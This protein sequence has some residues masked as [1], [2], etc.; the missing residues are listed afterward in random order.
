MKRITFATNVSIIQIKWEVLSDWHFIYPSKIVQFAVK[1]IINI[2]QEDVFPLHQMISPTSDKE[3]DTSQGNIRRLPAT[4]KVKEP[5]RKVYPAFL[6]LSMLVSVPSAVIAIVSKKVSS[7]LI[8]ATNCAGSKSKELK[9][10]T[11]IKPIA[12]Q[13]T[14]IFWN[15][16]PFCTCLFRALATR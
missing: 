16:C 12:N 11:P 6:N 15:F 14:A 2:L 10:M 1:V 4:H 5:I 7:V 9:A 8:P 3:W 13:G